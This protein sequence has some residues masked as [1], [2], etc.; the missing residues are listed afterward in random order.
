MKL[1]QEISVSPP[2]FTNKD[3]KLVTPP[4]LLFTTLDVAY[5][6][7]PLHKKVFA[8]IDKLPTVIPLLSG[9]AYDEAGDYTQAFIEN[10]LKEYLGSD[11]AAKIRSLFPKTLEEDP[12]G[13]GSILASMFSLIGI[14]STPTCS[15]RQHA[16]EMNT[17]GNAWCENNMDTII[18]WL[19]AESNKRN[20]PFIESLAKMIVNKAIKKSKQLKNE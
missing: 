4:P 13:P 15:C 19:K 16:I 1:D 20:I 7:Y 6:D 12:N 8:K 5:T 17:K 14:K 10:K 3:G 9:D 2:P 11:P 18:G